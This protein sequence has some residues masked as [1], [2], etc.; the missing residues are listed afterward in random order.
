MSD[1]SL[2]QRRPLPA[3]QIMNSLGGAP[4][5]SFELAKEPARQAVRSTATLERSCRPGKRH[6]CGPPSSKR[7]RRSL[8]GRHRTS[9]IARA[10]GSRRNP[11]RVP[12]PPPCARAS[13]LEIA[14]RRRAPNPA[15]HAR[16]CGHGA[17]QF[18]ARHDFLEARRRTHSSFVLPLWFSELR[19]RVVWGS[20][21]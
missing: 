1:S 6:C 8:P 2:E 19:G 15:A 14:P 13:R 11:V 3:P 20:R 10:S 17:G 7:R 12:A 18:R 4:S 21:L 5:E 16:Q 9:P